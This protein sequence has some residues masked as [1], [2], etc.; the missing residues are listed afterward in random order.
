[1]TASWVHSWLHVWDLAQNFQA[2]AALFAA[3]EL[4]LFPSIPGDGITAEE[5]A[6]RLG[7]DPL[8]TRLLLQGLCGYGLLSSVDRRYFVTPDVLSLVTDGEVTALPNIREFRFENEVWLEMA[9]ALTGAAA[10][11][12]DYGKVWVDNTVLRFPGVQRFNREKDEHAVAI[13]RDLVTRARHV[14]EPGGG[15]GIMCR[16]VLEANPSARYTILEFEEALPA[17]RVMLGSNPF[18]DRVEFII[19]DARTTRLPPSYDLVILNDI[20]AIF[21]PGEL[22]SVIGNAV[23]ALRPGGAILILKFTLDRT[24]TQPPFSA[25]VSLRMTLSR[26]GTYLPTDDEVVALVHGAG[27]A[28][29]E[30]HPLRAGKRLIIGRRGES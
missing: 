8:R 1:M 6:E 16:T 28:E 26:S 24:G 4:D 13:A 3:V 30:T 10:L 11:P 2:S 29:V 21:T 17:C 14:L 18:R 9:R 25:I 20:L 15:D 12:P 5:L 27:C 23:A 22:R 19:G 7:T